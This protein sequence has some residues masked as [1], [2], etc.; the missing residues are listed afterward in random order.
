MCLW[1]PISVWVSFPFSLPLSFTRKRRAAVGSS[2][3]TKEDLEQ[4]EDNMCL[5][6]KGGGK[7]FIKHKGRARGNKYPWGLPFH[8]PFTARQV[9]VERGGHDGC[10]NQGWNVNVVGEWEQK[11][12]CDSSISFRWRVKEGELTASLENITRRKMWGSKKRKFG[13]A[14]RKYTGRKSFLVYRVGI[15]M[16]F[17]MYPAHDAKLWALESTKY[18]GFKACS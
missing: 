14:A 10:T 6:K 15:S 2:Q 13:T 11:S 7:I 18:V 1:F 4:C 17:W 9:H 3:E 5:Q 8:L 16:E 12:S